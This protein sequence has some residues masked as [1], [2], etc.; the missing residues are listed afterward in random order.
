MPRDI[1]QAALI[2][3][4]VGTLVG[5]G[6]WLAGARFSQ[7]MI[8]LLGVAL[9]AILGRQLPG[10][11]HWNVNSMAASVGGAVVLGMGGFLL[12]R[13]WVAIG[14]GLLLGCWAALATWVFAGEGAALAW[15]TVG[16]TTT[17]RLFADTLWLGLPVH[18]RQVLPYATSIAAFSGVMTALLWPR[19][20]VVLLYSALGTSLLV[21]MGLIAIENS[22]PQWIMIVPAQTWAQLTTLIGIVA[23]GAVVQWQLAP[24]ANESSAPAARKQ[25]EE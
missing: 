6:L 23:F 17:W 14:L 13:M 16:P 19:V 9:G 21:S 1:G 24:T 2:A 10:W 7:P 5:A 20:A 15:P 12:H 3:A 11:M 25:A 8:T 18:V 22:R 4:L